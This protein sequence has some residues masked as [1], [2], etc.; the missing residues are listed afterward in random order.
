MKAGTD[1]ATGGSDGLTLRGGAGLHAGPGEVR[2][3]IHVSGVNPTDWKA[4]RG[5]GSTHLPRPQVPNQDGAGVVDEVGDGVTGFAP[6]DR[7][8]VWDAAYQRPDGTAQ[9]ALVLP[10]HLVVALPD[11]ASFD[12]GASFGIPALTA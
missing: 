3:R 4:R 6:G 7:V 11:D 9:E 12:E 8:W 2:V 10:E 1:N 5:S